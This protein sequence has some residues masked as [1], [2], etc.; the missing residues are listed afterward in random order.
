MAAERPE[1]RVGGWILRVQRERVGAVGFLGEGAIPDKPA[2]AHLSPPKLGVSW[3]PAQLPR[4]RGRG[5]NSDR[6][7]QPGA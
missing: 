2:L 6:Y 5:R 1:C 3:M 7:V 4:P